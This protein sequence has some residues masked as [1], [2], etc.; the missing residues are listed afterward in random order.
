MLGRASALRRARALAVVSLAGVAV[1]PTGAAQAAPPQTACDPRVSNP[2]PRLI[3]CVRLDGGREHQ[4]ARQA[5]ADDNDGNRF[6]G[7]SGFNESVDYVVDTLRASGYDPQV[8][9]F[10]YL[11]YEVAGPSVLRQVAPNS[12]TYVEGTDFG[13]ITQT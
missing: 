12:I 11:A 2:Y 9:A 5:I 7:F 4:A 13:A 8:Q 10:D 6:S 3:V 1:M